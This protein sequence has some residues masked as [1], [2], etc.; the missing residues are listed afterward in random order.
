MLNKLEAT[1]GARVHD[2]RKRNTPTRRNPKH[3]RGR[4]LLVILCCWSL[5]PNAVLMATHQAAPGIMGPA[6]V[7]ASQASYS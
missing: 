6:H 4:P 5:K 3:E 1:R 7:R 2:A